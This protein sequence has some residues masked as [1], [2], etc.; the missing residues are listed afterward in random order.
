MFEEV[1]EKLLEQPESI[2]NILDTFDCYK[3]RINGRE[4]RCAREEGSNPTAVVIRLTNNENLLVKDYELNIVLDLINYLIKI[5][6]ASFKDVMNAIKQELHLDS[7]YNYKRKRGLFGG[8]YDGLSRN[9]NEI[10]VTTYPEEILKQYRDTPN[11][12]WLQDGISLNTQRKWG[13]GFDVQSQRITMPIRTSTGEIMAVK[14]RLN[15]EPEEFEPKY[16][17]IVN[18]PMSQTLFGYSENYNSLY[19]NEI[20]IV[21]SEKSVLKLDSWGYNN[22]VALG[23]NSLSTT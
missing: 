11:L 21:E 7:I 12:L 6:N 10:S 23:S 14:G 17:Y 19:E 1:K 13:I 5:K 20:L 15:G 18:G 3:T 8:L 16:L 4:I 9:N 2:I 22:V